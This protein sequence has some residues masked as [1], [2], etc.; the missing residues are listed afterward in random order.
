MSS[1]RRSGGSAVVHRGVGFIHDH[2]QGDAG[3]IR[4]GKAQK[5]TD[6]NVPHDAAVLVDLR[7]ARF[8]A[9][10][11]AWNAGIFRA[12]DSHHVL[13]QLPHGQGGFLGD[14][15]G[16][17]L[18]RRAIEDGS[19]RGN[20][21]LQQI[22]PHEPSAVDDRAGGGQQLNGRY[23]HALTKADPR[24]IHILDGIHGY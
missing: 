10:A 20:G 12:A 22:G 4:R 13:Q 5:R 18:G 3:I 24:Q 8:T 14:G 16:N 1:K 7:R 11:V 2:Q 6:V 19:V 21:L 17:H 15:I 23:R 9:D